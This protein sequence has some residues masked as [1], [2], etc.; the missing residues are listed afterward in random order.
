[1][2]CLPLQG[3]NTGKKT[4]FKNNFFFLWPMPLLL[5]STPFKTQTM[6]IKSF[7]TQQHC[8]IGF[9][10]NLIPRRDSNPGL[11]VTEAGAMSTAP[12]CH[13]MPGREKKLCTN[14]FNPVPQNWILHFFE[15]SFSDF[16]TVSSVLTR[17]ARWF[18]FRPKIPIWVNFVLRILALE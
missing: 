5:L 17:V 7:Y 6:H 18:V 1:M 16:E 9:P 8:Y 10:K 4:L 2:P 13:A 3:V 11:I 14:Q 12:R 15:T